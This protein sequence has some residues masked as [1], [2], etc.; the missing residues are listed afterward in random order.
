ME[1]KYK[2]S[3]DR[4]LALTAETNSSISQIT[5]LKKLL[6]EYEEAQSAAAV[7]KDKIETDGNVIVYFDEGAVRTVDERNRRQTSD[8]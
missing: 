8:W 4:C 1:E 7:E 2:A 5:Q 3:E 6:S